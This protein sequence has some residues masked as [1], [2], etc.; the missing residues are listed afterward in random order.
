LIRFVGVISV[1]LLALICFELY[2]GVSRVKG[3]ERE[4]AALKAS[5]VSEQEAIRVLKAEWSYL[6]QPERLQTLA[7]EHLPL[8]PTGA[9]QIVVLASLPL[10]A[11]APNASPVIEANELPRKV[12]PDAPRPRF[13]PE[14]AQAVP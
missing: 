3:Q 2:N 1:A 4:L 6:N 13:K 5:I 8:T 10:K 14:P 11:A 9:S 7:R 12:V